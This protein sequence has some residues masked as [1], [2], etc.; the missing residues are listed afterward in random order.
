MGYMTLQGF[1]HSKS[2]KKR[3]EWLNLSLIKKKL[4]ICHIKICILN[5]IILCLLVL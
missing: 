3:E 4:E 5:R 1:T 2:L